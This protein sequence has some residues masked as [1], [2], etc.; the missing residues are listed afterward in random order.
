MLAKVI[1]LVAAFVVLLCTSADANVVELTSSNFKDLVEN[2]N[3]N[4]FLLMYASWCGHCQRMKPE[5]QAL[6]KDFPEDGETVIAMIDAD[7]E[8]AVA[9]AYE[10]KGFPTIKLFTKKDKSG[11][12]YQGQRTKEDFKD[13]LNQHIK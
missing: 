6:A 4:V 7:K 11:I 8:R 13:F 3:K 10:V 5:W 2:P 12:P 1:V 9:R